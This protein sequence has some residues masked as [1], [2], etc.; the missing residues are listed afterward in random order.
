MT[1]IILRGN[2]KRTYVGAGIILTRCA[3]NGD[4]QYLLLKGRDTGI[5]SFSKGHPEDYDEKAPLRTAV[6]ETYE[7]TGLQVGDYVIV[8]D[9]I[10]FGKRPYW[11]GI[12]K[13]PHATVTVNRNEHTMA[14]WFSW[15]E[16]CQLNTNTDVRCWMKKSRGVNSRFMAFSSLVLCPSPSGTQ[17]THSTS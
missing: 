13:K 12:M 17:D 16:I 14:A 2:T 9:S 4:R 6:R 11:V 7:E 1:G 5:W 10:R 8:G 3:P 15:E